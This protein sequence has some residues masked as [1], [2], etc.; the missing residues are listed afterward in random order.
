M[1]TY[2]VAVQVS[3]MPDNPLLEKIEEARVYFWIVD[4]SPE[5]AMVR[6]REYLLKYLWK[7]EALEKGPVVVTAADFA[8]H[9]E[10]LKGWW[11]AKQKGFAAQFIGKPKAGLP[12]S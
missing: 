5:N 12:V 4:S 9:E 6:A 8:T 2:F 3:P 11:R 10:G 1:N 7:E